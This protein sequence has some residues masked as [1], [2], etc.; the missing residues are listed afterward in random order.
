[1]SYLVVMA[2]WTAVSCPV[3]DAVADDDRLGCPHLGLVLQEPSVH[4]LHQ[5]TFHWHR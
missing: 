2:E 3:P 5:E 1:M 4:C